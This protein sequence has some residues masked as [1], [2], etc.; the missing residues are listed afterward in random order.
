M[1]NE[2][3]GKTCP[4]CKTVF[5]PGDDVVVCSMCDMPHHKDCWAENGSCTTF[6]CAG[7]IKYPDSSESSVI[8]SEMN[9]DDKDGVI[10]APGVASYCAYC[11]LRVGAGDRFCARCGRRVVGSP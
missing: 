5:V 2:F 3:I 9:F 6:G 10:P 8:K 4:Y 7:A 11:G 1:M